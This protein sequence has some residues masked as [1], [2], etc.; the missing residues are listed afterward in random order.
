MVYDEG[1]E[2]TVGGLNFFAFSNFTFEKNHSASKQISHNVSHCGQTM[3][4]WYRT[5][6]RTKFGC[7]FGSKVFDSDLSTKPVEKPALPATRTSLRPASSA[8]NKP[9]TA[10]AQ[11]KAVKNLNLLQTGWRAREMPRWL[12][13]TP[14]E[15]NSLAGLQRQGRT[16]ALHRD[17]LK[18]H[19]PKHLREKAFLQQATVDLPAS[20]DWANVSGK[21]FLE[22]VVDQGECGSCYVVSTTRM[23]TARHKI[24]LNKT[25]GVG[26]FS[27][28]FPLMC[29][30]YNQGCKGG[31]GLLVSKWSEDVGLLPESCMPYDTNGVCKL[32]CDL[33]KLQGKR[34]RVGNHHYVGE[35]Y[36][37]ATEDSMKREVLLNGPIVVGI[38]PGEDFM[39]YSE[40]VF[41]TVVGP[42]VPPM[43]SQ[44]WEKVDHA[45]LL[46]GWGEDNGDKYWRLQNS[47]GE[48]WGED[49]FFRIARGENQCGVESIPE[50]ADV[51]EDDTVGFRV[52]EFFDEFATKQ[53]QF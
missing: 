29:S 20:F 3:V 51:V 46:V 15:L 53:V 7:Y 39:Y 17:M 9:V 13:R 48:D 47:W 31:Y 49:G 19:R 27:M 24:A 6:D 36:G 12:G 10:A 8:Y 32:Q 44:E 1:Y 38:E 40:G 23:L 22:P 14:H 5:E 11:K 28:N 45:V 18:Q 21:S 35:W 41:R 34:W 50:A 37:N 2:V 25:D 42:V 4:G 33:K 52:Q 26:A 30:E 16:R 43:L